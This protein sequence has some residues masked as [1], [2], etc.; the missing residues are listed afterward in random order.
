MKVSL[1]LRA[2]WVFSSAES[3][4]SSS[5]CLAPATWLWSADA[6]ASVAGA[7]GA[8]SRVGRIDLHRV[9]GRDDLERGDEVAVGAI[10]A[11]GRS[12]RGADAPRSAAARRPA[13]PT[14]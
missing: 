9:E 6:V 14:S 2:F 11:A 8:G 1:A 10:A 3:L 4:C 7:V 12:G 13:D 5:C